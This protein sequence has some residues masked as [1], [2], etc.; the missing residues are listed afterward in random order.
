MRIPARAIACA[1]LVSSGLSPAQPKLSPPGAEK[2]GLPLSEGRLLSKKVY[3]EKVY[4]S[5]LGQCVGNIYGLPHENQYIDE[6]GPET[7]PFGYGPMEKHLREVNGAFSDDDTD[8]EYMDLASMEE[9]GPEPSY[10]EIGARWKR[11]IQRKIWVA[12]RAALAAMRFGFDPPVTGIPYVNP[13]WFQIDP[14][15]V[16]EIWAITA[17]GMIRYA[18]AKSD[19]GARVT[20]SDWGVETTVHYGAMYAAAFFESDVNKLV[21]I[22]T[23]ALPAGNRFGKTVERMKEL[24]RTYPN[25]WKKARAEM[26]REFYHEEPAAT[27]TIWNANLNGACGILALLYGQGDFQKT[28]DMACVIGFDADNQAA[29]MSGL[30]AV[31]KGLECIPRE[32]LYPFPDLDWKE[33]FNDFYKNLTREELP[34]AKISDLARRTALQ[35]EKIILAHGGEKLEKDGET[36][37]SINPDAEYSPVLE[38]P[39]QPL[40]FL[41]VGQAVAHALVASGGKGPYRWEILEGELPPGL[42]LANGILSG[43]PLGTG[44]FPVKV[45]VTSGSESAERVFKPKVLSKNLAP[46]AAKVLAP[47]AS[48]ETKVLE[49]LPRTVSTA[50]YATSSESIRDGKRRG[51][52]SVFNGV[53][54]GPMTERHFYGYEWDSA[55][56]IGALSLTNGT[57]ED[58]GWFTS[59]AVEY[60]DGDGAWVPVEGLLIEPPMPLTDSPLDQAHWTDHLFTFTPVR[61]TGIRIIGQVKGAGAET[62]TL[63]YTSITELGAHENAGR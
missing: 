41:E 48:V 23:A 39:S 35:G 8:I 54:P 53:T 36:W 1:I 12:N 56:T 47:L 62:D 60:R 33:P 15:L 21:D 19:W 5:W 58:R 40:P 49:Q 31:A 22:G 29:T 20:N 59:I 6:P 24:H 17:P 11:H 28:L 61:T 18:A 25:D 46:E 26:A 43:A 3:E 63:A 9:D 51:E 45:R 16:N 7:F 55:R 42:S 10:A 34:D 37:Y 27:R 52:G 38:L 57:V 30:V 13:H 32:L 50:L 44:L 14:Q 4:A 2:A